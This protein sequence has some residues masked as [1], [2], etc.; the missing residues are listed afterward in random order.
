MQ[1]KPLIGITIGDPA[2]IGPEVAL[3]ASQD[4]ETNKLCRPLIIGDRELLKQRAHSLNLPFNFILHQ[5]KENSLPPHKPILFDI[6][7]IRDE[8]TLGIVNSTYGKAAGQYLETALDLALKG[9]ISAIV[10]GPINKEA[11]NLAGFKYAGQTEFFAEKTKTREY[12]MMFVHKGFRVVLLSTHLSLSN[13]IEGV[14]KAKIT[15]TISLINKE[16]WKYG[17]TEARIGVACL[18]PHCSEG[19]LFGQEEVRQII[20]A[21]KECQRKGFKVEGP[22][23]AD[24]IFTQQVRSRYDVILALYHDQG[25]IPIKMASPQG[26]VNVTLGLPIIRTSVDHGTGFDI[27][28]KGIADPSSLKQ[29][30]RLAVELVNNVKR[31]KRSKL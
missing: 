16:M 13:A 20:P 5:E 6:A 30:I 25:L 28:G 21:I 3:R 7:N 18:N 10:T 17:L 12:A 29:A 14:K 19:G 15:S 31:K 4:K 1:N 27:A 26:A 23:P 11:F 22:F 8:V 9:Y 24:S 2:G